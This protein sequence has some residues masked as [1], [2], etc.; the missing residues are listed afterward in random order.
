MPPRIKNCSWDFFIIIED[1]GVA[2]FGS[3]GLDL[4]VVAVGA[5]CH[6]EPPPILTPPVLVAGEVF[7]VQLL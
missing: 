6:G 7:V 4:R 1:D 5:E 3:L 2:M